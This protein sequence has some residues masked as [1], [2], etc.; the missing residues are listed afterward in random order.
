MG[1]SEVKVPSVF[2]EYPSRPVTAP[3]IHAAKIVSVKAKGF[4]MQA[5]VLSLLILWADTATASWLRVVG[6]EQGTIYVSHHL[7]TIDRERRTVL[8]LM[9]WNE[10]VSGVRSVQIVE[11]VDCRSK[12]FRKLKTE[13]FS[14]NMAKGLLLNVEQ[15]S[16]EWT[17][18]AS[19]SWAQNVVDFTCAIDRASGASGW[20]A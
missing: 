4:W 2:T 18:P 8:V 1:P 17:E 16:A 6:G 20:R 10:P 12:R 9:D 3:S 15:S 13:S 14:G 19:G 5:L 11:E 7:I